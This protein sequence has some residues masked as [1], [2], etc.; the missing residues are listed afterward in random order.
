M[1]G[2]V[3][4][5]KS[6]RRYGGDQ[7]IME[8]ERQIESYLTQDGLT[9]EERHAALRD[10]RA[11]HA[12]RRLRDIGVFGGS[13]RIWARIQSYNR[14]AGGHWEPHTDEDRRQLKQVEKDFELTQIEFEDAATN[15]AYHVLMTSAQVIFD[16]L[17]QFGITD[18][19]PVQSA[20]IGVHIG[21]K[22][23]ES[24]AALW[25]EKA[26]KVYGEAYNRRGAVTSRSRYAKDVDQL[27]E[28]QAQARK[29]A[30]AELKAR[31]KAH[32]GGVVTTV[33]GALDMGPAKRG[34]KN[35]PT[36]PAH[37]AAW[38]KLEDARQALEL[39]W[40]DTERAN[41]ALA[42]YRERGEELAGIDLGK[43][44]MAGDARLQH[45]L[46]PI[47]EKL[48]NIHEAISAMKQ[49]K[50]KPLSLRPVVRAVREDLLIPERSTFD[51][52]VEAG[53][54][55]AG[56]TGWAM[57]I[58]DAVMFAIS[59]TGLGGIAAG[60]YDL[61]KEYIKYTT[62][63]RLSNT[64]LD[65]SKSISDEDPSLTGLI[66]AAVNLGMS[67]NDVRAVFK[68]ARQLKKVMLEGEEEAAKAARKQLDE[69]GESHGVSDLADDVE[70]R[71]GRPGKGRKPEGQKPTH[72]DTVPTTHAVGT[73]IG[74]AVDVVEREREA[75]RA[76]LRG[77]LV[78]QQ[79]MLM[80]P[81]WARLQEAVHKGWVTPGDD[82]KKVLLRAIDMNATV[83]DPDWIVKAADDLWAKARRTGKD[84][85]KLLAEHYGGRLP[86]LGKMDDPSF[87]KKAA[88]D[89]PFADKTFA[90]S[91]H[92][93]FVHVF[94][95]YAIDLRYGAGTAQKFRQDLAKLTE[96][97]A[98]PN[99]VKELRAQIWDGV[100]D[101]VREGN[102]NTPEVLGPILDRYAGFN[103]AR[104]AKA[105]AKKLK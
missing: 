18:P 48:V 90:S 43:K 101:E 53:I 38:D 32:S 65:A 6:L 35:R 29:A 3:K 100:F 41:P 30:A 26:T 7:R 78:E 77:A 16:S 45:T 89:K 49:G 10:L 68:E 15:K 104:Q 72:G 92:G 59:F 8:R 36:D 51:P 98:S 94:Q 73:G 33:T 81:E 47:V 64:A 87:W 13:D 22:S 66:L 28:L 17:G 61:L 23:A 56:D 95:M 102:L 58:M 24:Q 21:G 50:L 85:E 46:A 69:L 75:F 40:L 99:S 76:Q 39:A 71:S 82:A 93:S 74:V 96:E 34:K 91:A 27:I 12:Q 88:M 79:T 9:D 62:D 25:L 44:G 5:A 11:T 55:D 54:E 42:A 1:Q 83:R 70:K 20:I 4:L 97:I 52:A 80:N 14:M 37:A 103:R 63:K 84:P 60:A 67:I 31:A 2:Q 86:I 19:T 57:K 105:A